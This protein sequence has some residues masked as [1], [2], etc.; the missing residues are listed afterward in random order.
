MRSFVATIWL[1]GVIISLTAAAPAWSSG[2]L[3]GLQEGEYQV[4]VEGKLNAAAEGLDATDGDASV[5]KDAITSGDVDERLLFRDDS[6]YKPESSAS[7]PFEVE[8][9]LGEPHV[10][11]GKEGAE[12]VIVGIHFNDSVE[13]GTYP[14]EDGFLDVGPNAAPVSILIAGTSKDRKQRHVFSWDVSG[15][16]EIVKLDR[17]GATGTF[18]FTAHGMNR[19]GQVTDETVKAKVVFKSVPYTESE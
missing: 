17:G 5:S 18:A 10:E 11:T 16:A 19:K 12:L 13:P 6:Y 14:I 15:E 1:L 3:T 8:I 7:G 4:T 2:G 9:L